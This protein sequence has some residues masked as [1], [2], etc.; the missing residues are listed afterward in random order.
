MIRSRMRRMSNKLIRKE[1]ERSRSKRSSCMAAR[2]TEAKSV[3]M[4]S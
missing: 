3:R 4:I 2:K 1:S